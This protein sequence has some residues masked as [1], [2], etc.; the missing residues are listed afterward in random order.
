MFEIDSYTANATNEGTDWTVVEGQNNIYGK[1]PVPG[2]DT[3]AVKYLGKFDSE[4]ECWQACNTSTKGVCNDW[5]WHHT[6]FDSGQFAGQCYFTL[7]GVWSP[8]TQVKVTSARGPYVSVT[9]L[10]AD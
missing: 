4:A 7:F 10:D 5:T 6:D 3:D 8:T 9:T 2:V 1:V